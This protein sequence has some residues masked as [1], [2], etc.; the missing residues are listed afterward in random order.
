MKKIVCLVILMTS[1]FTIMSY[2]QNRN[3]TISG[4]VVDAD[5]VPLP[6]VSVLIKGVPG[7]GVISDLDGNFSIKAA[8]GDTIIFQ[9]IGM[10]SVEKPIKRNVSEN[11]IE[12]V[13]VEDTKVLDEVVVTGLSSQKKVSIV[14]AISS[15]DVDELKTPATSLNNMLGGRVA[16]VITQQLSGEPGSN[17]SNF[18]IRGIGTFGASSGALVLIDGMEGRLQDVDPDDIQGFAILKDAAATA[19]YGV[20]GANGV[21]LI[22]TKKGQAGK[23]NVTGRLTTKISQLK[24]LP[25]YLGSYDYALLAN[26]ARAMSGDPDLYTR[27]DLDVIKSG[28]DPEM[29][30]NVNWIDEIM[31]KTSLQQNYYVSARGGG[32]FAQ[33]FLSIG[34]QQEGA[35]YNQP[36]SKF[37]EPVSYNKLT[38]R[39]NI[40]MNLTKTTQLY[41]GMDGNIIQQT[42]PGQ[43]NTNSLW[44]AVRQITPLMFPVMYSDGTLP[45][46]GT[47]DLSSPYTVLNY[48]GYSQNN[49]NRNMVT[50]RLSQQVGG[51]FE[52]LTL[53]GQVMSDVIIYFNEGR[54]MWPN[55]YRASG[56]DSKGQLIKSLRIREQTVNY[57]RNTDRWR[58]YYMETKADWKRSFGS[59]DLGALLFYYMED[60]QN[61]D[62]F[63]NLGIDAIPAR[64]QNLSGRTSYGYNDTY[65]IDANF[66]FTGSTQFKKGERF[67]LF[68]SVAV[69]WVPTAYDWTK[70][71]LPWLEFLKIRASYGLAGND[72]I[73]GGTRFPYL[74]L[75][76]N[77]A[78][79]YWGY[80]GQGIAE[81]T[82]GADNLKWEVAKKSNLG[83]DIMLFKDK[84]S[85]T[86]DF[87]KDIRENIYQRR[88]TLPDYLGLVNLPF[89]NVGTMHSYGS[90]GNIEF[91][92]EISK[93]MDF[94]I[95]GNYTFSE[96]IVDYFEENDLPYNYLSV[97]G[98][99][100]GIIRGYIAEGLFKNR[101]EIET[102]PDQSTFGQVRP[103]DIKYRDVNGDGRIN[104]D[105]RVPLSYGNQVPR[106]MYGMGGDFRYK[107]FTVG[108]LF[109]GA[110]KVDY[111]RSGMNIYNFGL[112]APGWIPFYNGEL[113]NVIKL[114]N[115][116]ANRWTPAWY[117][118]TT[119]TENPNAEFP[120][121]SYGNNSNNSQLSTFWKR[122]GSYLRFQEL[123]MRYKLDEYDWMKI[124]GLTSVDLEL[125]A[126]NLFTIDKVKFFDPEQATYNGGAYPIPTTFTFQLYLNF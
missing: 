111:Y 2:G 31:K 1:M 60:V 76:D 69:G 86:M 112:N 71:N 113:G 106:V 40:D 118:G 91:F 13:L 115:N 100:Y 19:V 52:G 24:R 41:F 123:S 51:V 15:V 97:T 32:N 57:W 37:K 102:S 27:L 95:R 55:M 21:V 121:L 29:Y 68:P 79:V 54:R 126:N 4:V 26:E 3:L 88:V 12:I 36:D 9:M 58:K 99:P 28:L 74:T 109:R 30:P 80:R 49:E 8:Q 10:I 11:D 18:W 90:D 75:I 65:F 117:S 34:M 103:G 110:A 25:E 48:T 66:G 77:Y 108:I 62:W 64:R 85:V 63:D 125:V 107:R 61:S 94:T 101:E 87:F 46:Y 84:L 16:G 7:L 23:L 14:G 83:F 33:Y 122:D 35:A 104:D 50:L 67:G 39:A 17:I 42:Q 92:Q 44:A 98:K 6:S 114:A 20:R 43:Q 47:Y 38:Y 96:N 119:A 22:T 105:D 73:S 45:T 53:S 5:K 120:R 116:P 78:S 72:N 56:R 81:R 89:S 59:H 124:F 82:I 70:Q 93:D